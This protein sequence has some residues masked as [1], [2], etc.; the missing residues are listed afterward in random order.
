M[1]QAEWKEDICELRRNRLQRSEVERVK[2]LMVEK[3]RGVDCRRRRIRQEAKRENCSRTMCRCERLTELRMFV[4]E[5]EG[6]VRVHDLL[7]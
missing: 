6:S 1:V 2:K 7:P 4:A 5:E 3:R